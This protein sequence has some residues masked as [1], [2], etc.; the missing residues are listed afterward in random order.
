MAEGGLRPELSRLGAALLV[1]SVSILCVFPWVAQAQEATAPDAGAPPKTSEPDEPP[2]PDDTPGS[3]GAAQAQGAAPL[4][5]ESEA[6]A[7]EQA[8]DEIERDRAV[9]EL[10]VSADAVGVETEAEG[11]IKYLLERIAVRGQD[12]TSSRAIKRF[13]P[14]ETGVAFDV[15]D[16]ELEALRYR[17]LGTGWFDSVNLSLERGKKPG[18]VVLVIDVVER[19]TLVF[20]QLAAG[21]GWSVAS[22]DSKEGRDSPPGRTPEPYLALGVAETNFLGT[23]KTVGGLVLASPDQQG[24]QLHYFDPV[25]RASRWSFS[26]RT[27]FTNGQEYFGGDNKSN[28]DVRVSVSCPEEDEEQD[29]ECEISPPVAVVD[30]WRAG[31]GFGTARDVGSFTRISLEWHGDFVYVPP[32]GLPVAASEIR[33]RGN[34]ARRVRPIDFSIEPKDSIV[35]MVTL[36]IN[37]DKRDSAVF[38]SRGTFASFAGDLASGLIVSDYEFVRLQTHVQHW[39]TLPWGHVLRP[40]LYAGAVFGN[41]PFFYNFF[42]SDLTDLQPS[43]ILGLNLD[44][45]PAP[46]LFGVMQCGRAFDSSCG[47]AISQVRQEELA[48]RVD[49]EYAWP[50]ARGRRGFLKGGDLFGTI[51]LY[52]LADPSDLQ[53]ALPGYEGIARVPVDL[54]LDVG[55]RLD[56]QAGVFQLGFSKLAW[57]PVQ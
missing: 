43:R 27:L 1:L 17:L 40:G 35:S 2:T 34:S 15:N 53:V 39:Y 50:F 49:L 6:D 13:V 32:S 12:K 3:S 11:K 52:G 33:G 38:P 31:L 23:G 30:Y 10:T 42:V 22:V 5:A 25:V 7:D 47:T 16:P 19:R 36:G 28:N 54:T 48:A 14:L 24:L 51:G 41:A 46:N 9:P 56:T 37:Y 8:E 21:V 26:A 55:V 57:L 18:W 4:E 45:R 20:Q 29:K 44:H